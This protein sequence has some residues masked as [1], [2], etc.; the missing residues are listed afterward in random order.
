MSESLNNE[1][2]FNEVLSS[3][4]VMV[5]CHGCQQDQP[6]NAVYAKYL[7]NGIRSCRKCREA[8]RER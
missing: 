5:R 8:A 6:V 1:D 3:Q 7:A 2:F 4:V